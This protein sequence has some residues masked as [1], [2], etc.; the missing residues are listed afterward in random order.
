MSVDA[1]QD[2][3]YQRLRPQGPLRDQQRCARAPRERRSAGAA[4]ARLFVYQVGLHAGMLGG[5][6]RAARCFRVHGRHR[7]ESRRRSRAPI[8][9]RLAWLGT[10]L[11]SAANAAGE[12]HDLATGRAV[13]RHCV[14][15]TDEELV[16]ARHTSATASGRL[17]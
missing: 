10:R 16:I 14:I 7:R 6:A 11:D 15:P 17:P 4:C 8:A 1:V 9:E 5:R 12:T 3:L 13:S 2:L